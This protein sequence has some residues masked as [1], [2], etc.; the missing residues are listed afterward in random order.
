MRCF[1][2]SKI[3]FVIRPKY[4]WNVM[5]NILVILHKDQRSAN[6]VRRQLGELSRKIRKYIHPVYT[7]R[8]MG[9]NI[10][11]KEANPLLFTNNA[12]FTILSVIW[13]MRIMSATHADT[14][15]NVWR[16]F[17]VNIQTT[18]IYNSSITF[19]CHIFYFFSVY[20]CILRLYFSFCFY[21][22]CTSSL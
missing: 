13:A 22:F 3:R 4:D 11:P 21:I 1:R 8:K 5:R 7:T 2:I 6:V 17:P 15:I 14:C 9:S 12:L 19:L 18:L 16:A 20:F 10:T